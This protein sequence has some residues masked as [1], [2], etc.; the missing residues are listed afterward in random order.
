MLKRYWANLGPNKVLHPNPLE[1]NGPEAL[2]GGRRPAPLPNP[3][4]RRKGGRGEA[5]GLVA[6]PQAHI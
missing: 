2:E 1:G 5:W 4:R 6:A 3:S